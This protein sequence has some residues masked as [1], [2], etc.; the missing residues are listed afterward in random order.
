MGTVPAMKRDAEITSIVDYQPYNFTAT[1]RNNA[2]LEAFGLESI[3]QQV[4]GK[5]RRQAARQFAQN[6]ARF[7]DLDGESVV[8]ELER[9]ASCF[10]VTDGLGVEVKGIVP[11]R[12]TPTWRR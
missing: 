5:T 8:E 9:V 6:V 4:W 7:V 1:V 10:I 11:Q 12:Y 3:S 2:L